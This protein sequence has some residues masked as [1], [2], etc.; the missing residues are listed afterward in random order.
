MH[1]AGCG[2]L[3]D[4]T[5][6]VDPAATLGDNVRIGP[7]AVIGPHVELGDD[8]E[9]GPHATV[10]GPA[11][12]GRGNRIFQFASVGAEP[13][14]KKFAGEETLLEIGDGNTIREFVT[15][16]RGTVQDQG[17]TRIGNDNWIMAYVHI[18]HDCT[19]GNRIV[20]ANGAS[21]AGHVDVGDDAILG[22]FTLVHQFCSIG[23]YCFSSMG[24]CIKQD[25]PPFVTVAGN[26]AVPHGVNSEGLRRQGF[27]RE[28]VYALRRAYRMLYKSGLRL[29]PALEKID[30]LA[31]S[32][33][34]VARLVAFIRDSRRGIVR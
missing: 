13:Q 12:I 31:A 18:A 15:I 26:P 14:D 3:I 9:V 24:S 27:A 21:L 34:P 25:V 2:I 5:A 8:C 1:H 32:H 28:D 23:A 22:G 30:E 4:P 17:V 11:R 29:E 33:P 6:Q 7:Y 16:N 19:V 20:F 10:F